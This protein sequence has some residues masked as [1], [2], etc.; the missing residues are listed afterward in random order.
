MDQG[1]I[2]AFKA[3]YL[4]Q[5]LQEMIRQ[6]NT[7]G[8]SLKEYWKDYNIFK[9]TDNIQMVWE[10][11]TV[12]C[13]KG[14]W[15]KIWPSNENC[16]TYCDDLDTL[17]KEISEIADEVGLDSVDPVGITEVLE[18]HPQLLSN[19]E[20]YDLAQRLT[21]QQKENDDKEDRGTK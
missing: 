19:E 5:S 12:S 18:S 17:I 20:I 13:M 6:T 2:A 21:E 4:H 14:V 7:S 3:Y 11:V 10:E 15:H 16:G 8:F 9:A 1:V